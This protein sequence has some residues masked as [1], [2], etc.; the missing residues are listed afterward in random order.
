MRPLESMP[1]DRRSMLAGS[2][3]L[4]GALALPGARA[5]PAPGAPEGGA[6]DA[7]APV[8]VVIELVGGNDG[9]NTLVPYADEQYYALRPTVVVPR[10][11]VLP[12]DDHLGLNHRLPLLRAALEAGRLA[13]IRGVGYPNPVYSHFKSFEIWHTASLAGRAAGDGWLARLR[14]A[15]W[16]DDP[17]PELMV[18]VGAEPYSVQSSRFGRLAFEVPEKFLWAGDGDGRR[19]YCE[20]AAEDPA[21][22][23]DDPGSAGVL[24]RIYRTL[25][26]SQRTSPRILEAADA[27]RPNVDYPAGA[28]GASLRTIAALI[29]ARIG[30]RIYSAQLDGFD[31]HAN[32]LARHNDLLVA[33]DQGLGAFLADLAGRSTEKNVLVAV[34]SEFGRRAAEN[35]SGGTDH[36]AAG[37]TLLLGARVRGGLYGQQPALDRLDADGNLVFSTDFRSVYATAITD[38]FGVPHE[39]VLG[40]AFPRLPVLTA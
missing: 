30:T 8:L 20:A 32:Q 11:E 19:S 28:F 29:E 5:R 37:L 10:E 22:A 24:A 3:S 1:L 13:L 39:R 27:Y 31:T 15:A 26:H 34:V 2:L 35:H 33:L 40:E 38:W 14:A 16:G 18:S 36:G 17:R 25:R 9:L 21:E 23:T 12:L 4:G 6:G 7:E